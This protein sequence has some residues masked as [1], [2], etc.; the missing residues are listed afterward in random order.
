MSRELSVSKYSGSRMKV[1]AGKGLTGTH[2][3]A[4]IDCLNI[5]PSWKR[6]PIGFTGLSVYSTMY[7]HFLFFIFFLFSNQKKAVT[8]ASDHTEKFL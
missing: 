7:L 8:V 5:P 2:L 4:S 6:P 3:L 1:Y